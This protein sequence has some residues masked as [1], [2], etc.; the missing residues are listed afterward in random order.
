MSSKRKKVTVN[1]I[2]NVRLWKGFYAAILFIGLI[3]A[4]F[5]VTIY[6]ST[7][8]NVFIPISITGFVGFI[9][10]WFNKNHYNKI[11]MLNGNFFP[12]LNNVFSW[13]FITCYIFMAVN[14][15]FPDHE[16]TI[17]KFP[18]V[19]KSSMSGGKGN[20]EK[21]QPLVRIDYFGVEKEL[22][23]GYSNTHKVDKADSVQVT[24]RKGKLGFDV[25][26]HYN[27]L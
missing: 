4:V 23:F 3:L 14:Y 15:Y 6:Q 5:E 21:R 7:V 12:L 26:E 18:I 9:A 13:G 27:V 2:N 10:F 8:I 1:T 25:F 20:R 22:V 24:V 16:I 17:Y 11:Y 19:E